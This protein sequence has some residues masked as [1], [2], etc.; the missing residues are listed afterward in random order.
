[1]LRN[2][3]KDTFPESRN[4]TDKELRNMDEE[5]IKNELQSQGVTKVE[6]MKRRKD[7]QLVPSDS[8]I[9]TI[10]NPNIPLEIKVGF[11]I[12]D[13]KVYI[14]NPQR[15]FNCQKYGHNKRFCKNE[16]KCGQAGHD[17]HECDNEAKKK[18]GTRVISPKMHNKL[19]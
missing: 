4:V 11:L 6:R 13:T 5:D 18:K 9:L 15:C 14:P 3:V 17:D 16:A 2:N 8:Y 12:R 19:L 1:M 7:G 10:N